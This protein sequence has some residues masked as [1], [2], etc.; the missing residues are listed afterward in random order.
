MSTTALAV[1]LLVIGYQTIVWLVLLFALTPF[2]DDVLLNLLKNW[3]E[4]VFI[5][6]VVAAYT[7]GAIMN[8]VVSRVWDCFERKWIYTDIKPSIMRAA[9]LL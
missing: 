3:K 1:E 5:A 6:S 8:G 9:I 4:I 2:Y 7:L